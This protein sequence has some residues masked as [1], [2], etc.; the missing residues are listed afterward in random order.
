MSAAAA[1]PGPAPAAKQVAARDLQ[2]FFR[3][4]VAATL[5]PYLLF[6]LAYQVFPA[7]R[8]IEALALVCLFFGAGA[9]VMAS[10]FFYSDT[11]VRGFMREGRAPRYLLVPAALVVVA[12]LLFGLGSDVVRAYGMIGF[13]VWQVH[14]FTR[15][16]HGILAFVSR[17]WGVPVR[18]AERV[19]ITLTDVAA[20]LATIPIITPFRLTF[21]DAWGWHLHATGLGVLACAWIA[22]ALSAPASR[23]RAGW[24][25]ELVLVLLLAFYLPLFLF[26]D[27]FSAVYIYL[28]AHGLQYL[29][30]MW[31][32]A[33]TPRASRAHALGVLG[34][35]TLAGG[36]VMYALQDSS[37]WG[38]HAY[39][40]LGLS[41]GITMWHFVL[42]AGVWRLSEPFQRGYMLE[43]FA[44]LR[45]APKPD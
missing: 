15:Q 13:W 23:L 39:A 4:L 12:T 29:V 21:L 5:V 45:G 42:D 25:R 34:V 40:L 18:P 22:Y 8:G 7:Q 36:A 2:L 11:Q 27:A 24:R 37:L 1:A 10:F 14:H 35:F 33:A 17:A 30:F 3:L 9:H 16:N 38:A 31:F 41:F 19:A 43:R 20:V 26:R 6:P 32:V 28:T 44:F